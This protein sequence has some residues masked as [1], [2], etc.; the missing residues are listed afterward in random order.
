M[1]F[2]RTATKGSFK[3]RTTGKGSFKK[4]GSTKGKAAATGNYANLGAVWN[5]DNFGP[6]VSI[7]VHKDS[8]YQGK[9]T[10]AKGRL[11]FEDYKTGKV[12]LVKYIKAKYSDAFLQAAEDTGLDVNEAFNR[13]PLMNLSLNLDNT[14]ALEEIEAG[15]TSTAEESD[16]A[17]EEV[18]AEDFD[19][20]EDDED[21]EA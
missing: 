15:D 11:M 20:S 19:G 6:S 21:Y 17:D 18:D 1:A 10:K 2:N 5:D 7:N 13:V 12:Y 14:T 16:T 4:G 8:E 9:K 3:S